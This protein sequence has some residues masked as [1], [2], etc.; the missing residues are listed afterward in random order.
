MQAGRARF[1]RNAR[2][3]PSRNF[4]IS[5]IRP[6]YSPIHERGKPALRSIPHKSKPMAP[7]ILYQSE[8]LSAALKLPAE[9]RKKQVG[10]ISFMEGAKAGAVGSLFWLPVTYYLSQG[11]SGAGKWFQTRLNNSGRT[12][13]VIMPPI[14][15]FGLVSEQVASRLGNPMVFDQIIA[16]KA[17]QLPMHKR[18]ANF[19]YDHPFQW[20][21][22][23]GV[24]TL[25]T[26]YLVKGADH[27]LSPSQRIMHTRVIAQFSV[28]SI[29]LG[30]MGFYDYMNRRGR[31]LETWETADEQQKRVA[32]GGVTRD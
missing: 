10:T 22:T 21:L 19:V 1:C 20:I 32:S 27:S 25:F 15:V 14:F 18:L 7:V 17:T 28:L 9:E 6:K 2:A 5:G 30:T 8:A 3:L 16:A 26:T 29:L 24:P 23:L 13:V 12:A 31:F 11:K 4:E